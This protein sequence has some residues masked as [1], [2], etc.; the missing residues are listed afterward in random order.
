[1]KLKNAVLSTI[2]FAVLHTSAMATTVT[3]EVS[4]AEKMVVELYH[5]IFVE[6]AD[7]AKVRKLAE[8]FIHPSY[9]Q[10]NPYVATGREP[11]VEAIGEWMESKP[12]SSKTVIKRVFSSG[13]Y[14]ILHVHS[15]DESKPGPGKAGV[16][17]F[18]V[19][20]GKIMEHWD[21]WQPI[22]ANMPHN[23]SMF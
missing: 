19:E 13:D 9:I 6:R 7:K 17:I 2:F 22:P 14:I 1:M 11:F 12:A 16:D 5:K 23:N 4:D 8:K 3:S 10:H 21:V 20:D 18:R 15:Y